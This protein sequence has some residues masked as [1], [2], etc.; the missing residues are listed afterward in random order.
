MEPRT[1]NKLVLI[2]RRTR[3]DDLV[4]RFNTEDQARFYVEH[5]G[6]DFSDYQTEDRIYKQAVREAQDLL[7]RHGRVH[8]VDRAFLPNFIFGATDTVVALG[9]DGL[10]ANVL[11]YLNGQLLV[12]V[13]P[14]V[15]RWEG[16][17]LPFTIPDLDFVIPDVFAGKR[18]I[19]DVTMAQAL[20]NTGETLYG[21]NDLFIGPRTH[22]SARYTI[23]IG[24]RTETHS[25]SGIIVSTGLGSTGWLRSILAGAT[26]IASALSDQ[27]LE[28]NEQSSFEWDSQYLYFSVREP[29]PSKTSAAEITFGKVTT[30]EPL[31]LV[32]NMP[33]NGVIFSD[34]IESDYLQFN[35]GTVATISLA[36]KKGHLVT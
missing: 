28:I 30:S 1:E 4:A 35:S 6:S 3:L 9:Q 17:L 14:D 31:V 18:P 16:I 22:T 7:L 19:N 32:S 10:V 20:L 11:K 25:S 24:G 21:V 29:W 36:K 5:L 23:R 15:G 12:G 13:N 26:G 27:P 33:E 34:G 2:I 8:V